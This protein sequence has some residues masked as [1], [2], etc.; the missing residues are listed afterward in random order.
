MLLR[1]NVI[2]WWKNLWFV[3][4]KKLYRKGKLKE[5]KVGKKD[6]KKKKKKIV[7][8][9]KEIIKKKNC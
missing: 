7:F 8:M 5:K 3:G 9:D 2:G 1:K 4:K 6:L